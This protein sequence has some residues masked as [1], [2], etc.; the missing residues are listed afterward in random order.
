LRGV[1]K[2]SSQRSGRSSKWEKRQSIVE[3][4]MVLPILLLIIITSLELGRVF[5]AKVVIANA[6]REGAYY[7][8][9]HS[10]DNT[11]CSG[12]GAS[13]V[14]YLTTRAA[15]LAEANNSGLT[16]TNSNITVPTS[17]CTVGQSATIT[18]STSVKN[19]LIIS[20]VNKFAGINAQKNTFPI[21]SSVT[22]VVQ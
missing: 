15:I 5:M 19:V 10:T 8:T 6:A 9:T 7:L 1:I 11:N 3:F 18:V 20:L 13:K 4:L 21:S 16:L 17:C 12:S 14:C 2:G 22:M